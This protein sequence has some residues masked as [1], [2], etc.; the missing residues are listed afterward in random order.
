MTVVL[1]HSLTSQ[2]AQIKF[3]KKEFVAV[4]PDFPKTMTTNVKITSCICGCR[5]IY[6]TAV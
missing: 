3:A 5:V 1:L 6:I 2:L 4:S